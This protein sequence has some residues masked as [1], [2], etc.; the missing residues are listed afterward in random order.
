VADGA[1]LP[2]VWP[3]PD[4]A[5]TAGLAIWCGDGSIPFADAPA[6]LAPG[7]PSGWLRAGAAAT[8]RGAACVR[9]ESDDGEPAA[10]GPALA[11]PAI[12]AAGAAIGLDPRPIA[13][14]A[15]LEPTA[16]IPC[17]L[18]DLAFGP[19]CAK[20][21]DDRLRVA[22]PEGGPLLWSVSGG[23]VDRIAV[24]AP[25]E[26]FVVDGLRPES[27]VTLGVITIDA[28]GGSAEWTVSFT[29]SA[30]MPH[31]VVNEVLANPLG[32]EPDQEWVE[33]FNDGSAPADLDGYVLEDLGGAT[34]LP[35]ATLA[36]GGYA[37]VVN[38]TFVEDDDIAPRPAPGTLVLRVP[39]LGKNGLTNAGE[40]IVLRASGG[41]VLSTMPPTPKPKPGMTVARVA[42]RAPDEATSSFVVAEPTPGAPFAA[43]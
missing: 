28:A 40:R 33:L 15:E 31:V 25:G 42:P 19:G 36:P 2:R 23:G 24:P 18:G 10:A 8:A 32:L 9:F 35:A 7:G 37:L 14:E 43:P 6:R 5:A 22:V 29:T 13:V 27:L 34:P 16:A 21:S 1:H 4:E 11:P 20:V 12:D 3:P 38:D 39:A 17:G 26:A 41:E 30:P